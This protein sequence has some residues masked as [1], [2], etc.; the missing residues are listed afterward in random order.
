[1]TTELNN[2]HCLN[3]VGSP[4]LTLGVCLPTRETGLGWLI[5]VG[6][7][8][9]AK[10][11]AHIEPSD[12]VTYLALPSQAILSGVILTNKIFDLDMQK[13][14]I[15]LIDPYSSTPWTGPGCFHLQGCL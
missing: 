3:L 11:A 7:S 6:A 4:N 14:D 2:L 15:L 13:G 5:L 1:M 12:K 8:H 9:V 10:I